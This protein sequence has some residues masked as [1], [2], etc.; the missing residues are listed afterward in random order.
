MES[1]S[2]LHHLY[3][4]PWTLLYAIAWPRL[5]SP[6]SSST[7]LWMWC[8][9]GRSGPSRLLRCVRRAAGVLLCQF[10]DF[11]SLLI[12][13]EGDMKPFVLAVYF[14]LSCQCLVSFGDFLQHNQ[15]E[16]KKL[17]V[18][19]SPL[20]LLRIPGKWVVSWLCD[21]CARYSS[22]M[23]VRCVGYGRINL[24]TSAPMNLLWTSSQERH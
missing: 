24:S 20:R 14:S 19:Q 5:Q 22:R 9:A 6:R 7:R 15:I 8:E 18:C 21:R 12:D 16:I 17:C 10:K 3:E 23:S 13:F 11:P 4:T 2:S 1:V